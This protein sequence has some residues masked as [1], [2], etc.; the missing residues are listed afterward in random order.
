M[1]TGDVKREAICDRAAA[2][3]RRQRAV[4]SG[5]PMARGTAILLKRR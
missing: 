2:I 3:Q 5:S 1:H 4:A